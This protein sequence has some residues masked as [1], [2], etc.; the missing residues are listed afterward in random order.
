MGLGISRPHIDNHFEI[1]HLD[2][3][4]TGGLFD[5]ATAKRSRRGVL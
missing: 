4:Q 2:N 5:P 3:R 1:D